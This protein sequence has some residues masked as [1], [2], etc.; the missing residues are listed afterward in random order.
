MNNCKEATKATDEK[1]LSFDKVSFSY[2]DGSNRLDIFDKADVT[3]YKGTLHAIIGPSGSGKTTALALAGA[4]DSP[5]EGK[6][7]YMGKDIRDIGLSNYR[8]RHAAL[9]F[10]NY[11][12]ITYMNA[13]E[14]VEMAMEISGRKIKGG[15]AARRKEALR[16]LSELGLQHDESLRN[17]MKLSGGQQQRV[18]IARAV[19]S[20]ASIILADEPTGNLDIKTAGDIAEVFSKLAHDYGKCVIVVTHAS[21]IA[22]KMDIVYCI[23]EGAIR[24]A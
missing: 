17:V 1:V 20:G 12:L 21:H 13:V 6:V 9:I 8:R 14:N 18:A 7:K 19:A 5:Q 10:Q 15:S 16:I 22:D 3:F 2:K 24:Y 23:E 4:L 11:N